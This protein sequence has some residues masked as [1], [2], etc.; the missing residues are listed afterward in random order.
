MQR[1]APEA[2]Q[3]VVFSRRS[4]QASLVLLCRPRSDGLSP[5]G[6]EMKIT[7]QKKRT[8]TEMHHGVLVRCSAVDTLQKSVWP[9]TS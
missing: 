7:R 2:A 9:V 6:Q 1:A 3:A 8:L 4:V 5:A